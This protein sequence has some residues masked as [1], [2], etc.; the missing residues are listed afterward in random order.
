MRAFSYIYPRSAKISVNPVGEVN[1]RIAEGAG[2]YAYSVC[3]YNFD[4]SRGDMRDGKGFAPL[5]PTLVLPSPCR[6]IYFYK[7]FSA[8]GAVDDRVLFY[9]DDG[10]VYERKIGGGT[11]KKIT[12]LHFS[13]EPSCVCYNYNGE[14][15]AILSSAGDGMKIY[16]GT[17]VTEV[18]SAPS[19]SSMCIHG[20]RLFLT[21]GSENNSLW[22]SDDFDPGNW[23]VSLSEAGFIDMSGFRGRLLKAIAF[24]GYVYVFRTYGITRVY[25]YGDQSSF[26]VA[27]LFVSSGKIRGDSITVCGDSVLFLASDGLYRFDGLSTVRISDAYRDFLDLGYEYAKGAF[28]NGRA[29]FVLRDNYGG[30][31]TE[32]LLTVDPKNYADYYFIKGAKPADIAVIGGET[33]YKL[34]IATTDG[35]VLEQSDDGRINGVAAEKIWLGKFGDFGITATRKLLGEVSFYTDGNVTVEINADGAVRSYFVAGKKTR[36][37]IRPDI[38]ADR[39]SVKIKST[40]VNARVVGLTLRLSYYDD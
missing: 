37:V 29:Y 18:D 1:G 9:C 24:G 12:D 28:Y 31:N 14:D 7:R 2:G 17:T 40:E 30:A 39:F 15:V 25:A 4:L 11:V 5:S 33:A 22:F 21:D 16:D 19:V 8:G 26:S 6:R 32:C 3:S 27:D 35:E 10:Y 34:V 23:N 36:S 13:D 20:E 38:R